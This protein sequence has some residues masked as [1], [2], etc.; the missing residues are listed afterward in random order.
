MQLSTNSQAQDLTYVKGF[1]QPSCTLTEKYF[2]EE[3][4]HL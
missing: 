2:P 1:S 3:Q 4:T